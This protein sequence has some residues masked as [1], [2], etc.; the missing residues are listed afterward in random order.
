[1]RKNTYISEMTEYIMPK[2][3]NALGILFGGKLFSIMD[4]CACIA[5][6][7]HTGRSAVTAGVENLLFLAPAYSGDILHVKAKIL[8]TGN[9]SI[10]LSVKAERE[11][12]EKREFSLISKGIFTFVV[13]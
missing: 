2:D 12:T 13:I 5:V 9:K 4:I 7:K 11:N 6:K 3:T 8:K 1:M 10:K